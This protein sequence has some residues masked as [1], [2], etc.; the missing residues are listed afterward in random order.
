MN[1][2][3]KPPISR[4]LAALSVAALVAVTIVP[5]GTAAAKPGHDDPGYMKLELEKVEISGFGYPR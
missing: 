1:A 2:H 3:Q 5:V 4:A